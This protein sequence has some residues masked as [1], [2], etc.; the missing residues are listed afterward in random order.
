MKHTCINSMLYT[1]IKN[2]TGINGLVK[3][4]CKMIKQ[5]L[6]RDV[7]YLLMSLV[8][9]IIVLQHFRPVPIHFFS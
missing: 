2:Y 9:P 5:Q 3:K 4:I 7:K 1:D 6:Y 8:K